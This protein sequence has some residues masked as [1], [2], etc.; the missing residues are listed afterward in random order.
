L[1]K[2]FIYFDNA[3]TTP[4]IEL[5]DGIAWFGNPSS[6]HGLGL[7]AER[8][9][10]SA[11]ADMLKIL[12][13]D[14]KEIIFTSGGTESN[15]LA[16]LGYAYA[17]KRRQPMLLASPWEHPSVVQPMKHAAENGFAK[18]E[19]SD[20]KQIGGNTSGARFISLSHVC[21]ETGD[22]YDVSELAKRLKSENPETVIHVDGAQGFC[23]EVID[24]EYVDLY[25]F[26]GHKFHASGGTGGLVKNK[27]LRLAPLFFG[28]AQENN[29][30]PG[31]ENAGGI[32]KMAAVAR[33]IWSKR[34][35]YHS[36]VAEIKNELANISECIPHVFVNTMGG[37]SSPYILNMS[38]SGVNGETIVHLLSEKGVYASMGAACRSR[39]KTKS[40]LEIMGFDSERA[41]SAVRFSFSHLNTL[42]EA[43]EAKEIIIAAVTQMRR[44]TGR[45]C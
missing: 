9:V 10:S 3:A 13:G 6:P 36:N 20:V 7:A 14:K 26:S 29:L 22:I 21:H 40:A 38:F 27:D 37:E 35:L 12:G 4:E 42:E 23:K 15:N 17:Q 28:G 32:L 18:V 24:L 43:A 34:E 19:L 41:K 11:R 33:Q 45:N 5:P 31:T 39:K 44:V 25:S 8:A 16:I 30:R 2:P 1:S